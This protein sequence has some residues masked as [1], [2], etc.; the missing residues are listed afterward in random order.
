MKKL[1]SSPVNMPLSES[2]N[3]IYQTVLKF[4]PDLS[5]NLMAI[6]VTSHPEDF[7]N[8]CKTLLTLCS[9]DIRLDLLEDNQFPIL[10][11][12]QET[13]INGI[14]RAQLNMTRIAPWPIFYD[15]IKEQ[16]TLHAIDERLRLLAYVSE[17][18]STPLAEMMEENRLVFSGKHTHLLDPTVFSFDT[19]WFAST[20]GAK[21]FH[22]LLAKSPERFDQALAFIPES[23][24]VTREQYEQFVNAYQQIFREYTDNKPTGEK[25][26]LAPATRLLAMKRPDQFIAITNQKIDVLC[27][28]FSIAKFNGFDFTSYWQDMIGTIR[29]SS[30]WHQPEPENADESFIWQHRALFLDVFLFA[31]ATM[32]AQSNYI[33]L[34]DKPVKLP[35]VKKSSN[36]IARKRT[37]ES[38]EM[39]VD[40]ALEDE[41]LPEYI[42]SKRATLI[43]QVKDGKSVDQAIS[44]MRAIFG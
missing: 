44:L 41:T 6:K 24:D 3:F 7:L 32:A 38:A 33:K 22:T 10:R 16:N 20:K 26:P 2:E 18:K 42:L 11:K 29:A 8:W 35:S 21:T 17:I 12:L 28:G 36:G 19:E 39:L 5:L 30:W 27:Q 14:S 1:L 15:F 31:D 25:A 34:R 43:S 23:E 9:E 40:K 13:L 37:I 4:V